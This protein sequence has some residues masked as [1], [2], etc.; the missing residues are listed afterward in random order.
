MKIECVKFFCKT[1][2]YKKH[3]KSKNG[4]NFFFIWF[5]KNDSWL[6]HFSTSKSAIAYSSIAYSPHSQVQSHKV[7]KKRK[8]KKSTKKRIFFDQ[9]STLTFETQKK[10][11]KTYDFFWV[12][13]CV[14]ISSKSIGKLFSI[15]SKTSKTQSEY[16]NR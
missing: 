3:K 7:Q 9:K 8:I 15:F 2:L 16:L 5:L 4:K 11:T 10:S 6:I 1:L 12:V 14:Q 13:H